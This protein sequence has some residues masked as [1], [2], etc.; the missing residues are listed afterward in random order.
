M[1][2]IFPLFLVLLALAGNAMAKTERADYDVIPLP[3]EVKEDST[4]VFTLQQGMGV[5]YDAADPEVFRNV[6]FLCQWVEDMTGIRLR[7]T[8]E[9]KKAAVR[10]S[11][12]YPASKDESEAELTEQ[13]KEAYVIKVDKKG[14]DIRARKPVGLFRAAQTLRKALPVVKGAGVEL[15][16][17]ARVYHDLLKAGA[18][19]D[20]CPLNIDE[21]VEAGVKCVKIEGRMK[22]PEYTAVVTGIYSKV[23]H[24]R[25]MPTEKDFE[26]LELARRLRLKVDE[27]SLVRGALLHDYFL[28]DWH[29]PDPDRPLHGFYHPKAALKNAR[30]DY[31]VNAREEDII[32]HHM[33][34]LTLSPPRTKEGLLVCLADKLCAIKETV[35][36]G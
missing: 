32:L 4:Q 16:F 5:A 9:D 12:D 27:D 21:L 7:L 33:F 23:I 15:P 6:Q 13:Q 31:G 26:A 17:A 35:M 22:R 29:E 11:L 14:L 3:K 34:P 1:K 28:Y 24:D 20:A 30:R 2:K 10:L 25:T 8:P 18:K 19:L 36:R